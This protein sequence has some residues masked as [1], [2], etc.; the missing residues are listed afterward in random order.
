LEEDFMEYL[1]EWEGSV[2]TRQDTVLVE[3]L[4]EEVANFLS[5]TKGRIGQKLQ[6]MI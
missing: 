4:T 3:V 2:N 6:L 1:H 5:S